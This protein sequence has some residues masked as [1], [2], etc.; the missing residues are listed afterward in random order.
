MTSG[1]STESKR[2]R[3]LRREITGQIPRFPNDRASLRAIEGLPLTD[4]LIA[5]FGWKLRY[6]AARPRRVLHQTL[7]ALDPRSGPLTSNL[8][9][10][11]KK[12]EEGEDLTPYLSLQ[13]HTR[14][15]TPPATSGDNW[16]D[17]DFLLNVMGLHHF[18]LGLSV[19]AAGHAARTNEVLFASVTR[20]TF[21]VV[22]LFDHSAFEN[23]DPSV[24]PPEREALWNAFTERQNASA[25]PGQLVMGGLGG[26]G[27]T[28]SGQPVAVTMAAIRL[29]KLIRE[30]DPK[31]DDK[32]H[33]AGLY[34]NALP[35]KPKLR[36]HFRHLDFGV[37]DEAA[38]WFG[39]LAKGPN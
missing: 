4:L 11:F 39:I 27:I 7:L 17:K 21:D 2:V 3:A 10:F 13:P 1:P 8:A 28:G 36:W 25:L 14:G 24:M 5:Y 29:V 12:V 16:A 37:F 19:E 20:D 6:V 23:D 15:F 32:A 31:L 9:A 35:A 30:I 26:L 34:G 18:H 33:V 22:G 38:R